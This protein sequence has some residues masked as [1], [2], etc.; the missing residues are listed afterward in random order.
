MPPPPAP[1]PRAPKVGERRPVGVRLPLPA[2]PH[3]R[4]RA[5]SPRRP[6]AAPSS[7]SPASPS[8]TQ[9]LVKLVPDSWRRAPLQERKKGKRKREK[10]G[11]RGEPGPRSDTALP[12]RTAPRPRP[13]PRSPP[14][15]GNPAPWGAESAR[16]ADPLFMV[17]SII[18]LPREEARRG[19]PGRGGRLRSSPRP[20]PPLSRRAS[21][22]GGVPTRGVLP[23]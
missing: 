8:I 4:P 18:Q 7:L 10:A 20:R 5:L 13:H 11:A 15:M 23:L 22:V 6:P 2:D 21:G 9:K 1:R 17:E 12:A 19:G 3:P 16:H 14:L